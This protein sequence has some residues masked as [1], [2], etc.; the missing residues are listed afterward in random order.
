MKLIDYLEQEYIYKSIYWAED[1]RRIV[2][3]MKKRDIEI[4]PKEAE[5]IWDLYSD[6]YCA[7]WLGLP[8]DD[9]QLFYTIIEYA[10]KKYGYKEE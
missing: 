10:K 3:V 5:K 1:V 6:S 7:Q 2:E 8:D 4:T 9:E